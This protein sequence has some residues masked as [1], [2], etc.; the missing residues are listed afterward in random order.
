MLLI[1]IWLMG[2]SV[3]AQ[4][5]VPHDLVILKAIYEGNADVDNALSLA[6]SQ[7]ET[8]FYTDDSVKYSVKFKRYIFVE[9]QKILLVACQAVSA[10]QHGHQTGFTNFYYLK[11]KNKK[12]HV[13]KTNSFE[14]VEPIGDAWQA[15][16]AHIGKNKSALITT[17]SSTGNRHYERS[18]SIFLITS[19]GLVSMGNIALDY[20]NEG[21]IDTEDVATSDE[22]PVE[23]YESTYEIVSSKKDWYD[24]KV[25]KSTK[26][27]APGCV[28]D[29]ITQVE[30]SVFS[31][32]NNH[33][34]KVER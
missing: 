10:Y 9:N 29:K 32:S 28:E 14:I 20:S 8:S 13:L 23:S 3:K 21:W 25:R 6:S 7:D 12:W 16:I 33:Y 19:E 26:T 5:A 1:L 30:E 22:C 2:P 24:I 11:Y 34:K 18:V 27:Y 15:D 4:D 31:F 17:F